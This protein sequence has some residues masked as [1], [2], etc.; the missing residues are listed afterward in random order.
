MSLLLSVTEQGHPWQRQ[1]R[2]V[3]AAIAVD[4]PAAAISLFR[5]FALVMRDAATAPSVS[6][7]VRSIAQ[8]RFHHRQS[9][10]KSGCSSTPWML[11]LP[12]S[13]NPRRRCSVVLKW[14]SLGVLNRQNMTGPVTAANCA[15]S[16]AFDDPL[17]VSPCHCRESGLNRTS[18][19]R[20][21]LARFPLERRRK[22]TSLAR[23]PCVRQSA[24]PPLSRRR[25]PNRP[26][27]PVNP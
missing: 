13:P 7:L 15:F 18:I 19:A 24:R 14:I 20:F 10:A 3:W 27:G 4:I 12:I 21:P 22:H 8:D 16:P 11:P 26:N 6:R 9:T 17:R 23:R 25:S 5:Q 1:P 2:A